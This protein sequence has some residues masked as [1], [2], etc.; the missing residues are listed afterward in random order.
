MPPPPDAS[1]AN[2]QPSGKHHAPRGAMGSFAEASPPR[3]I[4]CAT[5]KPPTSWDQRTRLCAAAVAI[6]MLLSTAA[7]YTLA[8]SPQRGPD[9]ISIKAG[10]HA[11]RLHRTSAHHPLQGLIVERT[12]HLLASTWCMGCR[13]ADIV[14]VRVRAGRG[15]A[16]SRVRAHVRAGAAAGT[17]HPS[18]RQRPPAQV[19]HLLLIS[20]Q[21]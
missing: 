1:P 19:K 11:P 20:V 4:L 8:S 21:L 15:A 7:H 14:A 5:K 6:A 18:Q 2:P 12:H 13:T 3:L 16:Q 10:C 9:L 17:D